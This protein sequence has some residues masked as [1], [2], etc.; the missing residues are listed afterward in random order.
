MKTLVIMAAGAGSRFGGPKQLEPVG[1]H[2]ERLFE[3]ALFDAR[4]SGFDRAVLIIREELR[5]GFEAVLATLP[6]ARWAHQTVGHDPRRARRTRGDR[7]PVCR[8]QCR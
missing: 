5:A 7:R 4:R 8:R 1:P 3:Y 6:P 2:G